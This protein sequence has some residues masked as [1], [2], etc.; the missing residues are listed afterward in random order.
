MWPDMDNTPVSKLL[1][2]AILQSANINRPRRE[3]SNHVIDMS[4][5][6]QMGTSRIRKSAKPQQ[7][8]CRLYSQVV[9][10]SRDMIWRQPRSQHYECMIVTC[11][12]LLHVL[13]SPLID[14]FIQLLNES[15]VYLLSCLGLLSVTL[16][17][18][19]SR[20]ME[21]EL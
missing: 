11:V 2:V 19:D 18:G 7:I 17:G 20:L 9:W 12:S 21:A 16:Q 8:F 1:L 6:G 5:P 4:R 15:T 14:R 3:Q 13:V 10:C